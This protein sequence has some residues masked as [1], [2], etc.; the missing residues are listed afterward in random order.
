MTYAQIRQ[1][2]RMLDSFEAN[3]RPKSYSVRAVAQLQVHVTTHSRRSEKV[4]RTVFGWFHDGD[5]P[6]AIIA[7]NTWRGVK[8]AAND[9]RSRLKVIHA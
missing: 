3:L 2:H 9:G 8:L 1:V 7:F 4:H 6:S 5:V